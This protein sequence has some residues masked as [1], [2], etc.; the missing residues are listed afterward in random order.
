MGPFKHHSK[1]VDPFRSTWNRQ[2]QRSY[3]GTVLNGVAVSPRKPIESPIFGSWFKRKVMAS[4]VDSNGL[5]DFA[6]EVKGIGHA[7]CSA[8]ATTTIEIR[9]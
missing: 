8:V 2:L 6:P 7:A 3:I 4:S 1:F 5:V 9:G